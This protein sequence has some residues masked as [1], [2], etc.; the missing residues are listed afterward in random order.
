MPNATHGGRLIKHQGRVASIA[1]GL[2]ACV[3]VMMAPQTQ[4]AEE[5]GPDGPGADVV[6]CTG[7]TFANGITYTNSDGMTLVLEGGTSST[8][9]GSGGTAVLLQSDTTTT[10]DVT[11]IARQLG[12]VTVPVDRSIGILAVNQGLGNATVIM[13]SGVVRSNV[14]VTSSAG[15]IQAAIDNAA[16]SQDATAVLNGG[17]IEL[18]GEYNA[19][20]MSVQNGTGDAIIQVTGGTVGPHHKRNR[21][22][23]L[24]CCCSDRQH[25][26][27]RHSYHRRDHLNQR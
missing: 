2:L 4:A 7:G 25:S 19:G 5:C 6:T 27:Y 13:D 20:V 8:V 3:L 26:V 14:P 1:P 16:N 12:T 22:R 17:L 10:Q 9:A 24:C 15:G 18:S 11:I 21:P 23:R